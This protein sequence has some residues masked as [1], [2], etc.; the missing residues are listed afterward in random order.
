MGIR[1]KILCFV[2]LLVVVALAQMAISWVMSSAMS[3]RISAGAGQAISSM[4]ESIR[5]NESARVGT[6]LLASTSNLQSRVAEVER[7]TIMAAD[8]SY[9]L[10][11][12]AGSSEEGRKFAA[13][14]MERF[15]VTTL[16][17]R[18]SDI[19]GIGA[20][21]EVGMFS[22]FGDKLFL[23][24]AYREDENVEYTDGLVLPDTIDPDSLTEAERHAYLAEEIALEYYSTAVPANHNRSTP[25]PQTVSWTSP[26]I[27]TLTNN[28][29]LSAVTPLSYDGRTVGTTYL[30]LALTDLDELAESFGSS[31]TRGA[32]SFIFDFVGHSVLSAPGQ[33]E[34]QP[35]EVPDPENPGEMMLQPRALSSAPL[36]QRIVELARTVSA[37]NVTSAAWR[38]DNTD[39]TLFV[40]NVHNLF[41]VAVLVPDDELFADTNMALT[42]AAELEDEQQAEMERIRL[43][44][45]VSL[46]AMLLVSGVVAVVVFRLTR[47]L[48]AIVDEL[49]S[50]A[51]GMSHASGIINEL[52]SKLASDTAQQSSALDETT[53]SLEEISAQ[54]KANAEASTTCDTA[55]R[56]ASGHVD[57]GA[58]Q[59]T[60]M[61]E[62]MASISESSEKIGDIIKTIESI[63]F[64]TNLLALNAAVEAARAGEAGKGFA[65]VAD[66]VRNLANRSAQAVRETAALIEETSS[67]VSVGSRS[68][69]ELEGGF[70]EILSSVA[71]AAQWVDRIRA[72]TTEQA[73]AI[74]AI[75]SSV[76]DL[77]AAVKRNE[78][79]AGES[80]STS[81]DLARQASSL[82][83]TASN[84]SRL[85][86]GRGGNNGRGAPMPTTTRKA[87][88]Y[89]AG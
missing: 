73:D 25:L 45:I 84:L 21:F 41:G 14:E 15:C 64:Q 62:A 30:D 4:G 27:D 80:S 49:N 77:D 67:R 7:A 55:M 20:T 36:G 70:K 6:T 53:A 52:A 18:M 37:S 66:E 44:G 11:A 17:D 10:L 60:H 32:K 75:N 38:R 50:D 12:L 61:R 3:R 40:G 85:T 39:F 29:M 47:S 13:R 79:A 35:M 34:W 42:R 31:L 33:A 81:S 26:Y 19:S 74:A 43:V 2:G 65:V 58:R 88:P 83:G 22:P 23:P 1:A 46:V 76:T 87:L 57:S 68:V 48:S 69:V 54:V 16:K 8:F 63:S 56:S 51:V 28:L 24:Y 89:V 71:E 78:V 86:N 72:S 5:K 82:S 9:T 59:V